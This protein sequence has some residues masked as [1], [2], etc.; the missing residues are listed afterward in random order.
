M[1]WRFH[2]F[3][4]SYEKKTTDLILLY[5]YSSYGF[6]INGLALSRLNRASEWYGFSDLMTLRIWSTWAAKKKPPTFHW[7]LAGFLGSLFHGLLESLYNWVGFHPLY[8]LNNQGFFHCSSVILFEKAVLW[9]LS[10]VTFVENSKSNL[11]Q[12][13]SWTLNYP[14]FL[15]HL[16]KLR[17]DHRNEESSF[18]AKMTFK[19]NT[20]QETDISNTNLTFAKGTS[21]TQKCES[22]ICDRSQEG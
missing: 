12:P 18:P 5:I 21:S 4:K 2:R 1:C 8:T 11:F 10:G 13:S 19:E 17:G 20:L 15:T 9:L 22:W 14:G 3:H 6:H 16:E 7:I